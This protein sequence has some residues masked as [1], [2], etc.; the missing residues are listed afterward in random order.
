MSELNAVLNEAGYATLPGFITVYYFDVNSS[1]FV[2]EGKEYLSEGVGIP[3]YSCV[4]APPESDGGFVPVRTTDGNWLLQQ[5]LRGT[6]VYDTST[7]SSHVI[8]A[9]GN[10]PDGYTMEVPLT[11]FDKWNG[12]AWVTDVEARHA[13]EIIAANTKKSE[14]IASVSSEISILQDAVRL[15]LAT[16]S[17]TDRLTALQTYRILLNRV[18]TSL[19]PDIEWPGDYNKIEGGENV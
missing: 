17:E 2:G 10:I 5:D 6:V 14:L 3:S 12:S 13:A 4:D 11:P 9:L 16:D 7:L 19:A 18:D 1:E 8:T 15:N